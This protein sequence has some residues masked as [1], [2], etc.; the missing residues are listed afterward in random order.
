MS[1]HADALGVSIWI[2]F[3]GGNGVEHINGVIGIAVC[4]AGNTFG[5]IVSAI[6]GTE[7]DIAAAC[8]QIHI[9]DISFSCLIYIWRNIS[10]IED[11][12]GPACAWLIATGHGHQGVDF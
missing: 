8:D 6:I 12:N 10:V 7:D 4:A 1:P 9:G 5:A 11:D 3:H 2:F